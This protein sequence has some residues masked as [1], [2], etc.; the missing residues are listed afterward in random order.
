[1]NTIAIGRVYTIYSAAGLPHNE[2][3]A[4][5]IRQAAVV[6]PEHARNFSEEFTI[7]FAG[8]GVSPYSTSHKL[9]VILSIMTLI[10]RAAIKRCHAVLHSGVQRTAKQAPS[11]LVHELHLRS[12]S[13]TITNT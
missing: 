5:I 6:K 4:Q 3:A 1:M 7:V 2:L 12:N 13:W 10:Y 8:I 9:Y 11:H